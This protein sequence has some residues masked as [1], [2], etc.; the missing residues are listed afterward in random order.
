MY[1]KSTQTDN[2]NVMLLLWR[3]LGIVVAAENCRVFSGVFTETTLF[4]IGAGMAFM[5]MIQAI[6]AEELLEQG[7]LVFTGISEPSACVTVVTA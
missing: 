3:I 6:V 2:T 1:Y 5:S 4:G 7:M